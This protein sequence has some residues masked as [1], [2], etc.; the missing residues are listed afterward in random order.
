MQKIVEMCQVV[1][2][3]RVK[4]LIY[5]ALILGGSLSAS[6]SL[7]KKCA[8]CHGLNGEKSALGKSKVIAGWEVEKLKEALNGYRDGSYGGAM[9]GIMRGQVMPLSQEDIDSLANYIS[10]LK[11]G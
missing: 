6:E 5:I 4:K 1:K 3:Y 8:S 7:Y 9:K 2:E 10:S 11:E